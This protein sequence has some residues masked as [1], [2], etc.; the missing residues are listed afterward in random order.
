MEELT[1]G[2][3]EGI[4]TVLENEA[5]HTTVQLRDGIKPNVFE[6]L[7]QFLYTEQEFLN[8]SIGTY[9]NDETGKRMKEMFLNNPEYADVIFHVE[10]TKIYANK[11]VLAARCE[12]MSVMF[13][14]SFVESLSTVSEVKLQE[15]TSECFLVLLEY[16]YTD[17]A[18]IED[19]DSVG[20]LILADECFKL[21]EVTSECFLALLEYLYTDHANLEDVDSLH[22]AE[23]L[24]NWCLHFISSNYIAFEKR[25]EF[26]LLTG[27]NKTH[28]EENRWPPLSYLEE[29]KE[30]EKEYEKKMEARREKCS[31]T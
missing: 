8:P 6:R 26:P 9:L 27:S 11:V 29:M 12:V 2:A 23:E 25:K 20:V 15:V 10:G 21:Q 7:L 30:Y 19:V 22:N 4:A 1:S 28:V 3:V 24:S 13:G 17:H 5:K 31:I 18:P 14:G 16:L